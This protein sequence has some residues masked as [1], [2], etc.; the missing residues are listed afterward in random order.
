MSTSTA[1][2]R[3]AVIRILRLISQIWSLGGLPLRRGAIFIQ[4]V[5]ERLLFGH[6]KF[7]FKHGLLIFQYLDFLFQLNNLILSLLI[8]FHFGLTLI[9]HSPQFLVHNLKFLIFI[10]QQF[11]QRTIFLLLFL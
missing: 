4:R 9:L 3:T 2:Y 5:I 6:I 11:F 7:I 8:L 10:L 1:E